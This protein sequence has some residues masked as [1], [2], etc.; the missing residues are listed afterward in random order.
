MI[1]HR[2]DGATRRLV[3]IG[4][5]AGL[6]PAVALAQA[7]APKPA[8]DYIRQPAYL[9][10][11]LSP[12]GKSL[13]AMVPINGRRNVALV[14]LEHRTVVALTGHTTDDV[15]SY[16]WLGNRVIEVVAADLDERG[17]ALRFHQHL[18]VDVVDK[19]VLG[20]LQAISRFGESQ[21][22]A[23]LPGDGSEMVIKTYDRNIA[24]ADA[25]RYDART[26]RKQLLTFRSPGSVEN[27]VVDHAGRVRVAVSATRG[28]MRTVVWM[29]PDND[30]E[31]T[32][33]HDDPA[34]QETFVPL[35]FDDDDRTLY[36]GVPSE[37][38]R[39]LRDVYAYDTATSTMG[40][41]V[42]EATGADAGSVVIDRVRHRIAGVRDGSAAGVHWVDPGWEQ[43]QR[44]L[45]QAL[46]NAHNRI[47]WARDDTDRM[48]VASEADAEPPTYY[49]FDR[50]SLRLEPVARARPWLAADDLSPRG[51]VSYRARDGLTIPAY[52][53]M[54][55]HPDGAKP[56]LVVIIHGGPFTSGYR[57]GYDGEAELFASRGYAVLQP[58]FRGT[59][60]Y[61]Q[62]FA[63]AGWRQWGLAMQDDVTDGVRWL[64]DTGR[65]DGDR[66]CLY[67]A[68][69]GGY[70]TLWGLEKEPTM[71]RCGVAF[72]AVSDLEL[73]FDVTWSDTMRYERGD[74]STNYFRRTLGD[75]DRGR[76]ALR[77][78]SPD[79]HADRLQAPLLLAY[80]ATDQRVPIIHGT[81]MRAALDD[82]HKPYEWVVYSD[83]QH[84][85]FDPENR[86]D[87]YGRVEA[88]LKKNLAPRATA[89]AAARPPQ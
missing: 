15:Y 55:K 70:A 7:P 73:M 38:H 9:S 47:S 80:G 87:F 36:V 11:A 61:G 56:P 24:S 75:P 41:R 16:Q 77:A 14:D 72:L 46:P 26:N 4:F 64:A 29:R 76:D 71:F 45:D 49:L 21:V 2:I 84:T 79:L 82:A 33:V 60:G 74:S 40:P 43:V 37:A 39:G 89:T 85:V 19:E 20:D 42:Y 52:L 30:A 12:D 22:L 54:P 23:A 48:I 66:V 27:F 83:Q 67:G 1:L 63:E 28:G 3:G 44:S 51:F 68:S 65:V 10:M 18:I 69:Y 31:W 62:A 6:L 57:Y 59:L 58:N 17:G 13:A 5:L 50:K 86:A 34:Q 8:D 32:Q 81:R 78:V 53:T 35:A 25:Y 88:F